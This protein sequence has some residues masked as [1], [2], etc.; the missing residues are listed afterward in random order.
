MAKAAGPVA[1]FRRRANA[2]SRPGTIGTS[3]TL[4]YSNAWVRLRR[5]GNVFT[6][7]YSTNGTDWVQVGQTTQEF[8][9]PVLLGLAATAGDNTWMNNTVANLSQYGDLVFVSPT[10]N[11]TQ[12]PTNTSVP[13]NTTATFN[14]AASG[15]GAP[16]GEVVYQWQRDNGAGFVDIAGANNASYN[17]LATTADHNVSFRARAYLAGLVVDSAAGVLTV[18]VDQTAP[19][20]TRVQASGVD[21]RVRVTFSEA[22]TSASATTIENYGLSGGLNVSAATYNNAT[23][24]AT[25]TLDAPMTV[26]TTYTV[27]VN[28]VEDTAIPANVIAANSQLQVIYRSLV[29]HWKLDD[30]TDKTASDSSGNGLAATFTT[31]PTWV[32]GYIGRNAVDFPGNSPG[33][34]N[35][36]STDYAISGSMTVCAWA[37][38]RTIS[39]GGRIVSKGAGS[40]NRGW[41]FQPTA[42]GWYE[43]A[44]A[45]NKT[46]HI[47]LEASSVDCDIVGKWTHVTCVYDASVPAMYI[48]TN[49]ILANMKTDG[50]PT[51]Q[52]VN[53][54]YGIGIGARPLASYYVPFDGQIDDV[55][56]YSSALSA[57]E[58]AALAAGPPSFLP[59]ARDASGN[60]VISWTGSGVLEQAGA[61]TG[62]WGDAP[63]QSNPQTNAPAGPA[64][65]YRLRHP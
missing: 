32:P 9:G 36:Y 22:V 5:T 30:G 57:A 26:G 3:P 23:R 29:G 53:T 48:Y 16:V 2:G 54:S 4:A 65:F 24:T 11:F 15:T 37:K 40:S 20:L 64:Q 7:Y 63:S 44:L 39:G 59:I 52:Y 6:G 21:T 55:R 13:N 42:G 62:T 56:L 58:I 60:V 10:L 17:F 49:G 19:T 1:S 46:A 43:F 31:G 12:S 14:A 47:Y 50:V 8:I 34:K 41:E 27:T 25:L 38:P 28:N 18:T 51:S 33:I 45:T 61:V 35:A